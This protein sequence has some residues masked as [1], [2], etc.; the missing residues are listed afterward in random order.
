M[1]NFDFDVFDTYG[2]E[3]KTIKGVVYIKPQYTKSGKRSSQWSN[4]R[5][6]RG[7][8]ILDYATAGDITQLYEQEEQPREPRGPRELERINFALRER[9]FVRDT[10]VR[11][12]NAQQLFSRINPLTKGG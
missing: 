2:L 5:S 1:P 4:T 12:M 6:K 11:G 8:A 10:Y 9:G 3:Y 7:K